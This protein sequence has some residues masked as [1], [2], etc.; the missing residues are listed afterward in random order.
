MKNRKLLKNLYKAIVKLY[1]EMIY[2]IHDNCIQYIENVYKMLG[3]Y[4]I[5]G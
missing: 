3:Y 5:G 1:T 2:C 4:F